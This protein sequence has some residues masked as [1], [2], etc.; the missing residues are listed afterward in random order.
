MPHIVKTTLS[1]DEGG[2]NIQLV[3][4][5]EH[6]GRLWLVGGWLEDREL[7]VQKPVRLVRPLKLRFQPNPMPEGPPYSISGPTGVRLNLE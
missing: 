5:I 6:K 3:D 4:T 7:G 1:F 2:P